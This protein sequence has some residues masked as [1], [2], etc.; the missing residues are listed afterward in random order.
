MKA[1]LIAAVLV[2]SVFIIGMWAVAIKVGTRPR[3]SAQTKPHADTHKEPVSQKKTLVTTPPEPTAKSTPTPLSRDDAK[4]QVKVDFTWSKG[5]FDSIMLVNF[6]FTNP[7]PY[8]ARD[9]TVTCVHSAPSGTEI[10]RNT[11]TIYEVVPA[12]GRKVVRDFNMGFIHSQATSSRCR[13]DD[14]EM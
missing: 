10:D 5:G 13:I 2:V 7:T 3:V 12:K 11:R 14:L 9:I 4:R 1:I 8:P 6:T